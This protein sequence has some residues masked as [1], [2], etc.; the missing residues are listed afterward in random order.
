MVHK[1]VSILS[2]LSDI[3]ARVVLGKKLSVT[4]A[5]PPGF[6]V[7]SS[8]VKAEAEGQVVILNS[9]MPELQ[10]LGRNSSLGALRIK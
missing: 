5:H 1:T 9:V 6:A 8:G 3:E 2:L 7:F 10:R 4:L